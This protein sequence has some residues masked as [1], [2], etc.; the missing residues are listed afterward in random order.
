LNSITTQAQPPDGWISYSTEKLAIRNIMLIDP[1]Q[2]LKK[3]ADLIIE[4]GSITQIG[5]IP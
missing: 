3:R 1:A 4:N 5:E 2:N